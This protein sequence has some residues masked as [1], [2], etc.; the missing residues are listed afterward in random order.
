[1]LHLARPRPARSRSAPAERRREQPGR[2]DGDEDGGG[3]D[4]RDVGPADH[5]VERAA[6]WSGRAGRSWRGG[7]P[8]RVAVRD[9][10][11]RARGPRPASC[12]ARAASGRGWRPPRWCRARWRRR[13]GPSPRAVRSGSRLPVGSSARRSA[14]SA[15]SARATATRC[16]SP[17]ESDGGNLSARCSSPTERSSACHLPADLR[18]GAAPRTSSGKRDVLGDRAVRQQLEVLEHHPD[19]AAQVGDRGRRGSSR[20]S[21]PKRSSCPLGRGLVAE[22]ELEQR[23][24][25]RAGG[26]GEEDELALLDRRGS[27]PGAPAPSPGYSFVT[28]KS[29]ITRPPGRRDAATSGRRGPRRGTRGSPR[30]GSSR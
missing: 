13:A 6:R 5:G 21:C 26:A 14:G 4:E 23:R 10:A 24:L 30:R 19:V 15:A 28:W 20:R 11:A 22:D 1:M 18:A 25:A 12:S 16:C 17:P 27:R 9:A 8:D 29:W 2:E 7:A 3:P